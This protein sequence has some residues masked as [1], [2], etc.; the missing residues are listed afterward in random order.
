MPGGA[1]LCCDI[2]SD[3]A[4]APLGQLFGHCWANVFVS[5]QRWRRDAVA[6]AAARTSAKVWQAHIIFSSLVWPKLKVIYARKSW[7]AKMPEY[8]KLYEIYIRACRSTWT[9]L[10]WMGSSKGEGEW[11]ECCEVWQ[12]G[13]L[14]VCCWAYKNFDSALFCLF[15]LWQQCGIGPRPRPQ[16]KTDSK[17]SAELVLSLDFFA[18]SPARRG[19]GNNLRA[20]LKFNKRNISGHDHYLANGAHNKHIK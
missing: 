14:G 12:G 11:E 8:S 15:L 18:S 7:R 2:A 17:A 3:T 13:Q 16:K 10:R 9:S 20:M 19:R 6:A 4:A 5:A 1:A